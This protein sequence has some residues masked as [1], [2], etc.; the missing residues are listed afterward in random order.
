MIKYL[1]QLEKRVSKKLDK[2]LQSKLILNK[3]L[4]LKTI[5]NDDK[6]DLALEEFDFAETTLPINIHTLVTV[7]TLFPNLKTL[8]VSLKFDNGPQLYLLHY[9]T[10][11]DQLRALHLTITDGFSSFDGQ[12]TQITELKLYFKVTGYNESTLKNL[13]SK[14]R[15]L[16][17]LTIAEGVFPLGT[18][19]VNINNSIKRLSIRNPTIFSEEL[20]NFQIFIYS[21]QLQ[22]LKLKVI[23]IPDPQCYDSIQ[24]FIRQYLSDVPHPNLRKLVINLPEGYKELDFLNLANRLTKLEDLRFYI[25]C[26]REHYNI[27]SLIPFFSVVRDDLK[28]TLIYI[29]FKSYIHNI[30]KDKFL[31]KDFKNVT[32]KEIKYE[33]VPYSQD[34]TSG[35]KIAGTY[36]KASDQDI[37][38]YFA[39]LNEPIDEIM[40][41]D[42]D[43]E[44]IF[45]DLLDNDQTNHDLGMDIDVDKEDDQ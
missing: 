1:H 3:Y 43:L 26:F 6:N 40:I 10:F 13:L 42:K 12:M 16:E 33:Y 28:I 5:R 15:E 36:R 18:L 30:E 11:F 14:T 8:K 45:Q 38:E 23:H 4:E 32:V 9:L 17:S 44:H 27:E 41:E 35:N 34:T 24:H 7:S 29:K 19:D 31:L 25:P 2:E 39:N 37:E 22:V 20:P 21:L